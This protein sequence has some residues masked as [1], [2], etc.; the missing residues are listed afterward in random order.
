LRHV[1]QISSLV[2]SHLHIIIDQ[3]AD[4][5]ELI[6]LQ[7]V[8]KGRFS[9]GFERDLQSDYNEMLILMFHELSL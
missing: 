1:Y 7:V 5:L 8:S 4:I 3:F 9:A 2:S 6:G